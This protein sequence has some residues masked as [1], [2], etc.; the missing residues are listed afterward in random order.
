MPELARKYQ[1]RERY[2]Y[3]EISNV[4][5]MPVRRPVEP[6]PRRIQRQ[7]P[8]PNQKK[9]ADIILSTELFQWGLCS[10]SAALFCRLHLT[11][12]LNQ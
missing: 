6:Q 2:Y 7:R 11:G 12:L 1:R 4:S 10:Q 3:G 8:V 5:S 9:L